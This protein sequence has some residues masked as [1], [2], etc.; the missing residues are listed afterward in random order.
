MGM[1]VTVRYYVDPWSNSDATLLLWSSNIQDF[2][3]IIKVCQ[4]LL[5]G[6]EAPIFRMT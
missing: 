6:N 1:L 2:G 3:I 4:C 5:L